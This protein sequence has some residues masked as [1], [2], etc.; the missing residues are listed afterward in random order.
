MEIF[1]S[2]I[3]G[4]IGEAHA[5]NSGAG[6]EECKASFSDILAVPW[7]RKVL[8]VGLLTAITQQALGVAIGM[9]FGTEVLREA[10][11]DT[12]L[13]LI[14]NVAIGVG[15]AHSFFGKTDF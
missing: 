15:A 2:E 10:G 14:G 7:L 6:T 12:K 13:A 4:V 9:L 5:I 1:F 3:D 8:L 11:L